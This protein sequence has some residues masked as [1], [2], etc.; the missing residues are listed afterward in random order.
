MSSIYER[1]SKILDRM[2]KREDQCWLCLSELHSGRQRYE[3]DHCM[4]PCRYWRGETCGHPVHYGCLTRWFKRVPGTWKDGRLIM[5][6]GPCQ[7]EAT[8][9]CT[10]NLLLSKSQ[11]SQNLLLPQCLVLCWLYPNSPAVRFG[12]T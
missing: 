11:N 6:C 1:E 3:D 10:A 4:V 8:V 2:V 12:S 7:F 5:R 9:F